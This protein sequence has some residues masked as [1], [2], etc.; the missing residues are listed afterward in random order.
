[1][2]S[3]RKTA[4]TLLPTSSSYEVGYG[5]PPARTRFKPGHSGNPKGRPKGSRNRPPSP[6]ESHDR[7]Q[8][9]IIQEAYRSVPI[10]DAKGTTEIPMAQAVVRSLAVNAAKGS[11]RA[12]RLFTE[13]LGETERENRRLRVAHL[14]AAMTYKIAWERELDRRKALGISGP[15]PL[16]HPDH[17]FI[18]LHAGTAEIRGPATKEEKTAWERWAEHRANFQDELEQLTEQLQDPNC[19]DRASVLAEIRK[20]EE[21]LAIVRAALAG[22]RGVLRFLESVEGV[23]RVA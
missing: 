21:V 20:S 13:L 18:D 9:I 11:Q 8:S 12:Q 14:E 15:E 7:L 6:A 2:S 3:D 22:S 16:P 10:N 17:I 19:M 1:M 23:Q 4:L 5:R